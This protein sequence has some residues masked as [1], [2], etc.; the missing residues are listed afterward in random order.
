MA[1]KKSAAPAV[2][3]VGA[4]IDR[5][6]SLKQARLAYQHEVEAK[7]AEMSKAEELIEAELINNFTAEQLEKMGGTMATASITR[8]PLP[9][10]VDWPVLWAHIKKTGEFDLLEKRPARAAFRERVEA[11][12][13]GK[14]E[15]GMPIVN[16]KKLPPGMQKIFWKKS[17]SLR[18][19]GEK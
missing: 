6:Y 12:T 4:K 19:V 18:K 3:P 5:L 14:G 9:A 13:T 1:T 17:V 10:E 16:A 11:A 15:D 8:A 7:I 2:E